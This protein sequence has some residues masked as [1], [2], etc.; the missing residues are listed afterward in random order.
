MR[1]WKR[2]FNINTNN[3][4]HFENQVNQAVKQGIRITIAKN[5][6]PVINFR[7]ISN[8]FGNGLGFELGYDAS[9]SSQWS[10]S[11]GACGGNFTTINGFLN[12]PSYPENYPANSKCDYIISQPL[13]VYVNLTVIMFN[14]YDKSCG[15]WIMG[16]NGIAGD[17]YDYLEIR[18][19]ISKESPLIGRFCGNN[20]PASLHSTKNNM[21]IR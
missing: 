16:G 21:W 15:D 2:F 17:G 8:Y 18:D 3:T 4:K 11:G 6:L 10:H 7:F 5:L 1:H 20:I 12:S 9:Q 14:T 19:G 13:G